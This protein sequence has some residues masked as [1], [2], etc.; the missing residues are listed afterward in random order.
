MK[1]LLWAFCVFFTLCPLTVS[2]QLSKQKL[3]DSYNFQ[4]G[5]EAYN[6]D[7]YADAITYLSKE[8]GESPKNGYAHYYLSLSYLKQDDSKIDDGLKEINLS[9]KNLPKK[10]NEYTALA[11]YMRGSIHLQLNDTVKALADF[12]KSVA[13]DAEITYPL[14]DI[15][16]VYYNKKEAKWSF[17]RLKT[18]RRS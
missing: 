18:L 15:G 2:A 6:D 5:L 13:T 16:D 4:R 8:I 10:D 14:I 11:Y 12:Q 17:G 7:E 3:P 1:K 9:I